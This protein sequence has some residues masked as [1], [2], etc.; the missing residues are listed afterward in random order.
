MKLNYIMKYVNIL[1]IFSIIFL[2]VL[3][4]NQEQGILDEI[5]EMFDNLTP[6]LLGSDNSNLS[7]K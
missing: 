7:G 5:D 4:V 6:N 2:P 1:L 3:N